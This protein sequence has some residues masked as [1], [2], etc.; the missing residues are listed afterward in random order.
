MGVVTFEAPQLEDE[1]FEVSDLVL[2]AIQPGKTAPVLEDNP[3]DSSN[4]TLDPLLQV[5]NLVFKC[6][7]TTKSREE[8][9]INYFF[10]VQQS[11][12][13]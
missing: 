10:M 5:M 13:L 8:Q 12:L 9:H 7:F 1:D 3:T 2:L 11:I 4:R 6:V